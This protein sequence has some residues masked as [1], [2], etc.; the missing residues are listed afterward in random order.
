VAEITIDGARVTLCALTIPRVGAW[1]AD[2]DV[3]SA[4]AITG[5]VSLVIDG[6]TWSGTV[7]RGG[8]V[9]GS[10]RGRIVGGAGGL[11]GTLG[12]VAQRGSTLG[13][14]LADALL[15]AGET[16]S[17]DA[18]DLGAL[19]NLWHR[20]AAPASTAVAD[21]ARAAGY[22]WRTLADGS[23]WLGAD[24]WATYTPTGAVDVID[25]QPEAGRL[26]LAGDT[27]GIVPGV[28]LA[29]P[30]RDPVRV[31]QV[32]HRATPSDLRTVILA[33]GATGLGGVVDAVIRR[34]LRRVDYVALYPARVVSQSAAG[35]LDLVPDDARV[36]PCSGVPIRYGLPG[37]TAVVP[38]GER[39]TL[40]YEGGDPS[41]PVAT[42][43]TAGTMTSAAVNASTRQAARTDDT[44]ADG[45]LAF[46]FS[47][48]TPSPG[49]TTMTITYTP[50]GGAPQ[51]VGIVLT[52][53]A[54]L[55]GPS[56]LTLSGKITGTSVL[57]A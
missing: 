40:T 36:P 14:V 37:V 21:V 49:L 39:V 44:T 2:L 25:E 18:H 26:V 52:G 16:L 34:A 3:D 38:V 28:T 29:L 46:S 47:S 13:T 9:A 7:A 27:L 32:E 45:T 17:G 15:S 55:V 42:L 50:P 6:A 48:G 12:A 11:A 56:T 20:I 23:V 22:S 41:K 31:G 35:L 1:V 4:E 30:G 24:T 57:R 8:L 19:A 10:W 53:A 33:D 51:A 54:S 5:R 43:W